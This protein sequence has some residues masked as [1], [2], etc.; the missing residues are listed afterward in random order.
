[1]LKAVEML[2]NYA[3]VKIFI[4]SILI[5]INFAPLKPSKRQTKKTIDMKKTLLNALKQGSGTVFILL[6][7]MLG[8]SLQVWGYSKDEVVYYDNS[9]TKWSNV[10]FAV[11]K[12]KGTSGADEN[13]S[14]FEY[15]M[16]NIPG[17]YLYKYTVPNDGWWSYSSE[18][19][20]HN[21]TNWTTEDNTVG[22]RLKYIGDNNATFCK[23]GTFTSG[24][25]YL[26]EST[27][28]YYGDDSNHC[29]LYKLESTTKSYSTTYRVTILPASDATI[30]VSYTDESGTSQSFT[31]GYADVRLT[32]KLTI[33]AS[34]GTVTVYGDYRTIDSKYVVDGNLSVCIVPTVTTTS[35]P[36]PSGS[37]TATLKGSYTTSGVSTPV[38]KGIAYRVDGSG[39]YTYLP[40]NTSSA[41]G[42]ISCNVTGLSPL[43][44]Y[45]YKAYVEPV[46][47]EKVFGSEYSFTTSCRDEIT[48]TG[49]A[50]G[51]MT[52][53][54]GAGDALSVSA[55]GA[56]NYTYQWYYNSTASTTG[57]TLISG[58][59][60]A[61]YSPTIE[62]TY[63]YYCVVGA[64]TYCDETSSFSGAVT[65]DP[66]KVSPV[67]TASAS[68]VTN[69][70][71]VTL[72]ATGAEVGTWSI[73]SG[74]SVNQ[75][76]YK[77]TGTSAMFKGNVG[78][79]AATT[80][81]IQGT[82]DGCSGTT[83]VTVSSNSD[84]C[85]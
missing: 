42:S 84:N 32:C 18:F 67:I 59:E 51:A 36:D 72:T 83:T 63:Y 54:A 85:Q 58:A 21:K 66:D 6:S 34:V 16:D 82:A 13:K 37:T 65:Y 45:Y 78:T 1:M 69:Y 80:Y 49:P 24:N 33:T 70:V 9:R 12:V 27:T 53:C 22:H 40:D 56:S 76:L 64:S 44:T 61:S 15:S 41:A 5:F 11:G 55:S 62:G 2:K 10:Y 81:T 73:I 77:E 38:A 7:M 25:I 46:A 57:A 8:V 48:V 20:F 60:S 26:S 31:S 29:N 75:Y 71:P 47:G 19:A 30:T 3:D 14:N 17:T 79:G 35:A 50:S 43:T 4:A 23:S 39:D 74:S 52:I 68:S 28:T